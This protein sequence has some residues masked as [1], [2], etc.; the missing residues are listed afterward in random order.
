MCLF[1][2][3]CLKVWVLLQSKHRRQGVPIVCS[4]GL[5]PETD[6]TPIYRKPLLLSDG[7]RKVANAALE[8]AQNLKAHTNMQQYVID[9]G[10]IWT[11]LQNIWK[12]IVYENII[13]RMMLNYIIEV[14]NVYF[15]DSSSI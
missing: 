5:P 6:I 14:K 3:L 11:Q 9:A 7:S 12:V 10:L 8:M 2:H 15:S 4:E 1:F 13:K